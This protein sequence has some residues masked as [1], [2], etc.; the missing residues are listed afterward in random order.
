[1]GSYS[2]ICKL[3]D[4]ESVYELY[5]SNEVSL[6]RLFWYRRYDTALLCLLDALYE[7]CQFAKEIDPKFDWKYHIDPVEGKIEN[8]SIKLQFNQDE[9]WT[10]SLK[11]FL[12]I[13][14][15]LLIWC[16]KNF[17]KEIFFFFFFFLG[18]GVMGCWALSR[19]FFPIKKKKKKKKKR[20]KKFFLRGGAIIPMFFHPSKKKKIFKKKISKKKKKNFKQK[21]IY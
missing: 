6:G 3:D 1:M 14:K 8:Y 2:K 20:K 17:L 18:G 21:K 5:G 12:T 19:C 4:V 9:K 11:Y 16:C 7:L 15:I 13:L 10:K